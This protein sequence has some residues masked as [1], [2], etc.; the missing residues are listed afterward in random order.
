MRG[1]KLVIP[2]MLRTR[3]CQLAHEGHPG[4]S[5]MKSRLRDKCW[6]PNMDQEAVK[7]CDQCE[8]CRLVHAAAPPEPM[9]RRKLPEK[10]WIDLAIDFLGPLPS[11]EYILVIIDYYSRYME[12]EIMKRITAQET[13][14]RLQ[15]I[16][17]TWGYPRT[18]TLDN[19]KQFVSQEFD[20]FCKRTG[21]VLNHTTPYWPQANGEV[22][23]QNRS[24]LKRLKISNAL[25]GDWKTE[26]DDYLIL[27]NNNPHSVTGQPPSELLQ[28]RKLRFKIPQTDDISTT[29]PITE[30]RDRDLKQKFDSKMAEDVR[31][32]SKPSVLELDDTVLMKNLLP[33][34]KLSTDFS[35]EKFKVIEKKGSNVTVESQV[36]G[37]QFERNSS[38]LL[39]IL[40]NDTE[41]SDSSL[42]EEKEK[43]VNIR[44]SSRIAKPSVRYSP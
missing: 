26:L 2:K 36:T 28:N 5:A 40:E 19:G 37:K 13:V 27:Y 12:I 10:P 39:K 1:M 8:E 16:F 23:R 32:G 21:I 24:L 44:R 42:R 11:G 6:W 4:H 43:D 25:Y 15:K 41:L 38:H 18:I 9:E 34:D 33:K 22:E 7:M 3:M 31:R 30:F 29:P 14:K 20:E 17:R 35:K